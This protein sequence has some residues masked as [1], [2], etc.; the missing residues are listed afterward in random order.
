MIKLL[1]GGNEYEYGPG[2]VLSDLVKE[3]WG[4]DKPVLM[5]SVNGK[6]K[7]LWKTV[8]KDATV[9]FLTVDTPSGR[10]AYER[11]LIF[12]LVKAVHDTYP[13]EEVESVSVEYSIGNA[14]YC[15]LV[16]IIFCNSSTKYLTKLIITV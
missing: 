2:I 4:G 7:E 5:A 14:L 13:Y 3:H 15:E 16:T 10:R 9:E 12:V 6:L 1:M 8:D 11:A